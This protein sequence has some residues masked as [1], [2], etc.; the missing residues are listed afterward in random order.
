MEITYETSNESIVILD[1]EVFKVENQLHTREHRKET[2]SNSYLRMGSAHPDYTFK[3]IVKSQMYRLRKLCS[4]EVDYVSAIAE[5]KKRCLNSG[6]DP[7]M[8]SDILKSATDLKREIT[9]TT[10]HI[11][12]NDNHKIRW[13]T[14]SHSCFENDIAKFTKSMNQVLRPE[15]IQFELVKTTAPSIGRL[16]FNNFDKSEELQ[17]NCSCM[18]CGNGV[19]G[20]KR[21]ITS[22]VTKNE[23]HINS[24]I[25]CYNSGIYGITCKC[26]SQYCGKTTVGFNKRYPEHWNLTSS[27]VHKH[28]QHHKCTNNVSEMKMQFLE[29]VWSRGKYSLSEREYL[30]NRRLKGVINIQKTLRN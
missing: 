16:L 2:A 19:R 9:S 17:Q 11:E 6:Y 29:N 26:V 25:K 7:T 27:S 24:D 20:D 14:L 23:Y 13:V 30:W 4:R 21:V 12:Q 5:L 8:V 3:G 18:V 10:H 15:K 1:I 22:S 28:L